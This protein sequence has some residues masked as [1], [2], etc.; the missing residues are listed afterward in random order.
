MFKWSPNFYLSAEPSIL[1]ACVSL[2][3][4]PIHFFNKAALFLTA[5]TISNPLKIDEATANLTRPSV[6]RVCREVDLLKQL[7]QHTWIGIGEVSGFWQDVCYE[8]LLPYCSHCLKMRHSYSNCRK[9]V[10]ANDLNGKKTSILSKLVLSADVAYK[11]SDKSV[12]VV[13]TKEVEQSANRDK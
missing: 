7:P 5:T 13:A 10:G 4:P 8:N 3:G 6:T 11:A 1:P 12:P 9:I 2:D